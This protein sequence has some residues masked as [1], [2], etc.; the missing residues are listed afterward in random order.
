[1]DETP[2][3]PR[4][5]QPDTDRSAHIQRMIEDME[6]WVARVYQA[7]KENKDRDSAQLDLLAPIDGVD[8]NVVLDYLLKLGA[9]EVVLGRIGVARTAIYADMRGKRLPEK[10][11]RNAIKIAR[12]TL[13]ATDSTPAVLDAA[14]RL[15]LHVL[16]PDDEHDDA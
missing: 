9:I 3:L 1:M 7:Y 14:V 16:E 10:T 11:I 8:M 4:D 15:A 12:A 2:P 13:K 5:D 6:A